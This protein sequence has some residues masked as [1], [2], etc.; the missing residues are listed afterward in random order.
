[1]KSKQNP[2]PKRSRFRTPNPPEFLVIRFFLTAIAAGLHT[3]P[4]THTQGVNFVQNLA[5]VNTFFVH[6]WTHQTMRHGI[7]DAS[8]SSDFGNLRGACASAADRVAW[9]S[10]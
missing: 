6:S 8:S 9:H 10:V 4:A 7:Y 3:S 2:R 1:M 5:N